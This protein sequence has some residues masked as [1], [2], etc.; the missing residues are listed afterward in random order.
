MVSASDRNGY[1]LLKWGKETGKLTPEEARQHALSILEAAEATEADAFMLTFFTERLEVEFQMA[2][3]ML[4][5]FRGYRAAK[6]E[7][8]AG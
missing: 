1:V 3:Q 7:H 4:R 2:L 5:D 6:A 8:H